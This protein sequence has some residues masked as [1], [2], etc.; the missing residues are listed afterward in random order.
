[1]SDLS[2]AQLAYINSS[3]KHKSDAV[4]DTQKQVLNWIFAVH[5]AGI[6]GCLGRASSKGMSSGLW[7]G[8]GGFSVGLVLLVIYGVVMFY[9]EEGHFRSFRDEVG[10]LTA[11]QITWAQFVEA[12]NKRP[13]KYSAC[14]VLAWVSGLSGLVGLIGLIVSIA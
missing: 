10:A 7:T 3:W 1:M 12:E 2:K 9:L 6:A 5:G 13:F 4:L 11:K 14:E 8:L